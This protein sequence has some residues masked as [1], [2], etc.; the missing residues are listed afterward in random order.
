[1]NLNYKH[2]VWLQKEDLLFPQMM[3][4]QIREKGT[5][6]GSMMNYV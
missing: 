4:D 6:E 2:W 5:R 3:L 1:M